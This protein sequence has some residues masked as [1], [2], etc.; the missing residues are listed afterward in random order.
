[1]TQK[2]LSSELILVD[3]HVHTN[4]SKDSLTPPG[5][6]LQKL[7]KKV[8][9]IVITDHN[10]I[11]GAVEAKKIN[12][13]HVI[14]GEEIM[15][16]KG[17]I[18]AIFVQEEV[19]A[20]L[21]P[22]EVLQR[23]RDQNAFVS[24]SH[25]FD[26]FRHGSWELEDLIAILPHIDAIEGFNSRV[27]TNRA[28]RSA[29]EF[30]KEYKLMI[31]AGSDAHTTFEVGKAGILLPEFSDPNQLRINIKEGTLVAKRSPWWVHLLSTLAKYQKRK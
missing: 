29:M 10:T 3:F 8:D 20:G 31:T 4:Y 15:T 7:A 14:V 22:H 9:R 21:P 23:L 6:L 25:P 17:E 13:E 28:N 30:A 19:P 12:S 5:A 18:L 2:N 11:R 16:T 24:V 26:T 1:M 27:M